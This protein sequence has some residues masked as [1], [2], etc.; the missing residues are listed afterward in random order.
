MCEIG[1][2]NDRLLHPEA[3]L[4]RKRGEK[5]FGSGFGRIFLVFGDQLFSDFLTRFFEI[6]AYLAHF[7]GR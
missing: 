1:W 5:A 6:F 4:K 3:Q 7:Q 2:K